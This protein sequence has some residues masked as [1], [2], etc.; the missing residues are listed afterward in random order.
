MGLSVGYRRIVVLL[1]AVL[2]LGTGCSRGTGTGGAP[3]GDGAH[4]ASPV[5]F[6][7]PAP[8]E[9]PAP[10]DAPAP[11][12]A[13]ASESASPP[14]GWTFLPDRPPLFIKFYYGTLDNVNHARGVASAVDVLSHFGLLVISPPEKLAADEQEVVRRLLAAGKQVY[15]YVHLATT[16]A[17]LTDEQIGAVIDRCAAAGFTGVFFDTAGYDYKVSRLRFNLHVAAAHRRGL[18]VMANAW[19]AQDVLSDA[20]DADMNPAGVAS[21]LGD[22]DW[23]LLE[24]F[25][26]R[27]DDRYAGEFGG[28]ASML[29][30]YIR[31]VS[32]ARAR[33]VKVVGLAYHKSRKPFS[34]VA[35]RKKSYDLALLLGLDGWSYGSSGDNDL[36]PWTDSPGYS[37]GSGYLSGLRQE[38]GNPHRWERKTDRGRIWFE[39]IDNPPTRKTGVEIEREGNWSSS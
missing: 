4:S 13:P 14:I 23:I 1:T 10:A 30:D 2:M 38:S 15:G 36:V 25:Y 11:T 8:T 27:S 6:E 34:D 31:A 37:A 16:L 19:H 12:D 3:S 26:S 32:G 22:G 7:R 17:P 9:A 18:Q 24:S 33:G 5:T 29:E 28:M 39:A 21:A 35:D 20:V